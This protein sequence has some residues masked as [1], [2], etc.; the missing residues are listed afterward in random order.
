MPET[1][2]TPKLIAVLDMTITIPNEALKIGD[3]I[4]ETN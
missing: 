3:V 1:K 4:K 2:M